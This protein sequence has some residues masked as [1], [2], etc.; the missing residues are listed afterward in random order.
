MD[1]VV[2]LRDVEAFEILRA[3]TNVV[4]AASGYRG[5]I[6]EDMCHGGYL[7][8]IDFKTKSLIVTCVVGEIFQGNAGHCRRVAEEQGFRLLQHPGH[9]SSYES[10]DEALCHYGG[11]IRAKRHIFSFS[12][13]S[14]SLNEAVTLRIAEALHEIDAEAVQRILKIHGNFMSYRVVRERFPEPSFNS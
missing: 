9:D 2:S 14:E 13:F 3:A 6:S 11:A 5:Q 8:V 7:T 12:G 10:R 4:R 1:S